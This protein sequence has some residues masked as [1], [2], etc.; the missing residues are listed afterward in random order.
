V[1]TNPVVEQ[2]PT[3]LPGTCASCGAASSSPREWFL[4]TDIDY[5]D[6]PLYAIILCD[7]CFDLLA[8]TCGYIKKGEEVEQYHKR[9]AELEAELHEHRDASRA[10]DLLGFDSERINNLLADCA[11]D[12]PQ[13]DGNADESGP[14]KRARTR[15]TS[16]SSGRKGEGLSESSDD[17]GMAIVRSTRDEPVR[18]NL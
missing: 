18:L 1:I 10:I 2:I 3:R 12:V 11:D 8:N 15:A 14:K 13:V 16:Q 6:T 5:F 17:E 4:D 9:I 7:I